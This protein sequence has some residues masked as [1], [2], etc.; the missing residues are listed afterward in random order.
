M[1]PTTKLILVSLIAHICIIPAVLWGLWWMWLLS[2]LWW[3]FIAITSISSGYH[4]YFSHRTF[5]ASKFYEIYCQFLAIFANSGP[6]LTWAASHRM[7]HA[8]SDTSK[9]PHSP[10]FKGFWQV[11]VNH[12]GYTVS[13]KRRF[14]SNLITNDSVVFFYKNYFK[15]Q[16]LVGILLFVVNPMLFLFAMALPIVFAF[17]GYGLINAYTH[18]NGSASNSIIANILTA[19]EGYHKFHHEDSKN[20]KIGKK[21]YHFDTGAWFIKFIKK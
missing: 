1:Q 6:V 21:W 12:W 3:Q 8:Y 18:I 20:W 2:F 14:L 17:H 10:K 15:L 4:R 19:G 9:D 5:N 13:I 11:Y 16:I 7:H